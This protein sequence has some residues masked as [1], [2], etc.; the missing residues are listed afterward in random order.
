MIIYGTFTETS[1]PKLF[2]AGVIPGLIMTLLFMLYIG[3][4]A[5]I[6]PSVAP[7][8]QGARNVREVLRALADIAPFVV[9]IA[10]T[11]GGLYFGVVTTT[12]AAVIGCFLSILLGF[13]FGDLT[14]KKLV[15]AMH[16]T[17][18][19]SGNIL[20]LIFAAYVFSY[21]ISFA[22][23]GEKLT[24]FIVG[25]KLTTFSSTPCCSCCSP[26]SAA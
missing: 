14:W 18:N 9:L 11:L 8:E 21:A 4:H 15:E 2:I 24:E 20:F 25:M 26:C 7:R 5:L 6:V 23:I 19:F 1:V 13:M 10:G 3:V 16:S 12:E 17:V 22:G